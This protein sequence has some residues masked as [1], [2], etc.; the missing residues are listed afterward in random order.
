[1][2]G[3]VVVSP[4]IGTVSDHA[5]LPNVVPYTSKIRAKTNIVTYNFFA[6]PKIRHIRNTMNKA[7]LM[8]SIMVKYEKIR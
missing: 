8:V 5:Q 6:V 1:M 7:I 3:L 2:G 4:T